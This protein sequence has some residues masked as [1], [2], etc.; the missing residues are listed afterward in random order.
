MLESVT[1]VQLVWTHTHTQKDIYYLVYPKT[2][3]SAV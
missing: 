2:E 3:I 1:K